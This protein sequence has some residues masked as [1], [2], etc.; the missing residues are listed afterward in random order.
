MCS[1]I[2]TRPRGE[3]SLSSKVR[4]IP[5][6]HEA[7]TR[8]L[9]LSEWCRM[10]MNLASLQ[11]G[12]AALFRRVGWVRTAA[13]VT[14]GPCLL[15]TACVDRA[16]G[17]VESGGQGDVTSPQPTT[18]SEPTTPTSPPVDAGMQALIV[19]RLG[20]DLETGCLWL[21]DG[22]P[23]NVQ[24]TSVRWGIPGVTVQ[25]DPLGL[26]DQSRRLLARPGDRLRMAGGA[27]DPLTTPTQPHCR[28]S[29][30][31]VLINEIIEVI[32]GGGQ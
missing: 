3:R 12:H 23:G 17:P 31:V 20:G 16:S 6:I 11:R 7:A 8:R 1:V 24:R 21:E 10:L 32:P 18:G 9:H 28:V 26:M 5:G 29:D 4:P 14:L 27:G 22:E 25:R 19:S 13:L 30:N 2:A 15:L